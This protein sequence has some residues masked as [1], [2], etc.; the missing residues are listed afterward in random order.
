MKTCI[1]SGSL[2]SGAQKVA[3]VT[4]CITII[5]ST[6]QVVAMVVTLVDMGVE[7]G[8]ASTEPHLIAARVHKLRDNIVNS[9]IPVPD[10]SSLDGANVQSTRAVDGHSC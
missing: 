2:A 4:K 9:I 10:G 8:R 7:M 6:F 1:P 3:D 5:G